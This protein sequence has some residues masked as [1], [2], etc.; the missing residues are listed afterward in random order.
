MVEHLTGDSGGHI[1]SI[2]GGHI[3]RMVEHPTGDS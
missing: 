2:S 3:A 1:S